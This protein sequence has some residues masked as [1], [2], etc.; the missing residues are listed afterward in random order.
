[1]AIYSDDKDKYI[2]I[3]I[4]P[5]WFDF[6]LVSDGKA[7]ELRGK[8]EARPLTNPMNAEDTNIYYD[9][10][11]L[12]GCAFE[13]HRADKWQFEIIGTGLD[14]WGKHFLIV[15]LNYLGTE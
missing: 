2:V 5:T 15:K 1:M 11:V 13:H 12:V 14:D 3:E 9:E 4:Q 8:D 10:E 7:V 6:W